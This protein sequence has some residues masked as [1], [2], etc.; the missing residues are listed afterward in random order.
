MRTIPITTPVFFKRATTV[1]EHFGFQNVDD[2]EQSGGIRTRELGLHK[3]ESQENRLDKH[4]LASV[5][6]NYAR[7]SELRKRHPFMFYTPSAVSHPSTPSVRVSALT[8]NT[9][10][11]GDPLAEIMV[12]K[13]ALSILEDIGIKKYRVRVNSIG[14]GDSTARF[15]R[16]VTL[17]VRQRSS[18]LPESIVTQLRTNASAALANLYENRHPI[19]FGLPSPL[20]FLT[21]PSRKY[22][23]EVLELLERTEI[24][25]TLDDKLYGDHSMYSHTL[26]EICEEKESDDTPPLILARGGRYDAL[27]KAFVRNAVPAVGIVIALRT[28][29]QAG[30]IDRPRTK[31]P[32]ACLIHIGREARIRSLAVV[33]AFRREKIPIEQCLHFERFSEQLAYAEAHQSKYVIILGQREVHEGVAIVRNAESRSQLTVPLGSLTQ[34]LRNV[35]MR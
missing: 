10:G 34:Y 29:D 18:E 9:I 17:L 30:V 32:N 25:F 2:R 33:E 12:L 28:K 3:H 22:F 11:A 16:E 35:T 4:V 5:L 14:D 15:V 20:D 1:A 8:L 19:T 6:E 23:K 24:P 27:T 21:A 26:F 7:G 13:C 31:K